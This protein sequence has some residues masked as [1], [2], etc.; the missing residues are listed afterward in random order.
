MLSTQIEWPMDKIADFCR[1]W[2]IARLDVFGSVLRQDFRPDSDVDLVAGYVPDVHWSLLDRVHMKHE[3]EDM[4]GRTVDL[5]NRRALEHDRQ[6]GR[7]AAI[8]AQA[9]LLYAQS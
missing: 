2:K 1:R 6:N 7:A 5:L 3:L 4:L 9:Q 8:L